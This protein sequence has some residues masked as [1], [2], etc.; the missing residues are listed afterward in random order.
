MLPSGRCASLE[1][2]R[3]GAAGE[4][5]L[6]AHPNE[7]DARLN[8]ARHGQGDASRDAFEV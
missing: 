8:I 3:R 1:E 5:A 6:L 2:A 4:A 7:I